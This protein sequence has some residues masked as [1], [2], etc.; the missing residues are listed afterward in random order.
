MTDSVVITEPSQTSNYDD[1]FSSILNILKQ[2]NSIADLLK[3]PQNKDSSI[4]TSTKEKSVNCDPQSSNTNLD[5][6]KTLPPKDTEITSTPTK[7]KREKELV[8]G[9]IVT[10]DDDDEIEIRNESSTL[11]R[12]NIEQQTQ[13]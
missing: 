11:V 2:R 6:C 9:D 12:S 13:T 5:T 8:K 4:P 10:I 7:V 3:G 1:S